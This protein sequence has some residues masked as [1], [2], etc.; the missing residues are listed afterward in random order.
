MNFVNCDKIGHYKD[1]YRYSCRSKKLY[2]PLM[3][4]TNIDYDFGKRDNRNMD[5]YCNTEYEKMDKNYKYNCDPI[6]VITNEE[7]NFENNIINYGPENRHFLDEYKKEK[8]RKKERIIAENKRILIEQGYESDDDDNYKVVHGSS[9][10]D[11]EE[12]KKRKLIFKSK[13]KKSKSKKS[14]SKK[15]KNKKS[16]N[17]KKSKK[18][19]NK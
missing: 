12:N 14:K 9:N 4:I 1:K 10:E 13:S 6:K 3:V 5:F 2:E 17:K 7:Y 11:D 15:S 18:S 19:L 8:E 16:K